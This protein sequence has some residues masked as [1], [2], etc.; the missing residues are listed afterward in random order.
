[1]TGKII[2][3]IGGFYYVET[4]DII[5]EC[6]A[7]GIFRKNNISPLAGD[8]V[9]ISINENSENRI[10]E[11]LPRKNSLIRPPVANLD[12]LFTVSSTVQPQINTFNIDKLI[13]IAEHNNIEPIIVF[14]KIDLDSCTQKLVDIYNKAGFK[15]ICCDNTTGVGADEVKAL[16]NDS[17]SAFT[18]NSG[19]GK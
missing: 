3:G 7:K 1:M 8:D 6:K 15:T 17:V 4:A 16:I 18:G 11:I 10:E 9:L 5:Y 14:T 13:A 19:V 12:Q 2:Q